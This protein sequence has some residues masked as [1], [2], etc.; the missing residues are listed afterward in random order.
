MGFVLFKSESRELL[1]MEHILSCPFCGNRRNLKNI[2]LKT[3]IIDPLEYHLVSVREVEAGPGRGHRIS[4]G[5]FP[6]IRGY[7]ILECLADPQYNEVSEIIRD[8]FVQIMRAYISA[9]IVDLNELS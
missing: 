7:N 2:E 6:K 3:D 9:G 4:T 8:R 1:F 5:G